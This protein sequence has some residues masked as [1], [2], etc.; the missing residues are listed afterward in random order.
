MKLPYD[1]VVPL[2]GI[3]PKEMNSLDERDTGISMFIAVPFCSR[4]NME[5]TEVYIVR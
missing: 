5:S 4:Q 3:H 1:P 2:Q